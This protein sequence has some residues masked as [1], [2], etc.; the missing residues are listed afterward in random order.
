MR[1]GEV[2]LPK[3]GMLFNSLSRRMPSASQIPPITIVRFW[4]IMP[5]WQWGEAIT[6]AVR[7]REVPPVEVGLRGIVTWP[8]ILAETVLEEIR[9]QAEYESDLESILKGKLL[10]I[11]M[12]YE[13]GEISEEQYKEKEKELKKKLE[14]IGVALERK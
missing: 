2:G 5:S 3:T 8:K 1:G 4:A 7:R 13:S 6:P 14:A 12:G 10:E 9:E 11:R